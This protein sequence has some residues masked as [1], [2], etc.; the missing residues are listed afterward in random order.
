M[1]KTSKIVTAT[2]L[3]NVYLKTIAVG[4]VS[5]LKNMANRNG[6]S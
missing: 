1:P 6:A 2:Q 4:G 3:K 5:G